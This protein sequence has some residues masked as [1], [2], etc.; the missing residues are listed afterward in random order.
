MIVKNN[1]KFT[2]IYLSC[3]LHSSSIYSNSVSEDVTISPKFKAEILTSS[4]QA[5]LETN[6]RKKFRAYIY[7]EDEKSE[8]RE[9]YS[10]LTGDELAELSKTGHYYIYLYDLGAQNF[11]NKR[12][13]AFDGEETTLN[14]EG[15]DIIVLSN[16]KKNKSDVLFISEFGDCSGNLFLAY[17]FSE[18]NTYLKNY[19]FHAKQKDQEF[20][21]RIDPDNGIQ[22]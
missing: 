22:N 15:A 9:R 11:L 12:T 4:F 17:G 2:L 18:N 14:I 20:Y 13:Q 6:D 1:N 21:G 5:N 8:W 19:I 3:V 16:H 10:C 7:A